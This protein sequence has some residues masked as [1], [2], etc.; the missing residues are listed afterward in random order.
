MYVQGIAE[1]KQRALSYMSLATHVVEGISVVE[2][3]NTLNI[4]SEKQCQQ[5]QHICG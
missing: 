3:G 4:K 1:M 5:R 2:S